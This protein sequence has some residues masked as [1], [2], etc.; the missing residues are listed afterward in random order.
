MAI[1]VPFCF[2][3]R[4][5][6]QAIR[7]RS[8]FVCAR[9]ARCVCGGLVDGELN[10]LELRSN[11]PKL[12]LQ[13]SENAELLISEKFASSAPLIQQF[14]QHGWLGVMVSMDTDGVVD[15][16][17]I[18]MAAAA[19]NGGCVRLL[20]LSGTVTPPL[21]VAKRCQSSEGFSHPL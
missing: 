12:V 8:N 10:E 13:V 14:V 17:F 6:R 21:W 20:I 4:L 19:P 9:G 3:H 16:V 2:M 18:G 5:V 7:P 1:G 11:D 15:A